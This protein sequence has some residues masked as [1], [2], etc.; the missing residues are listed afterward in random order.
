MGGET[1]IKASP[2]I[3]A[4]TNCNL[5]AKVHAGAF[6]EDLFYR[7]AAFVIA[8]PPLRERRQAVPAL[9]QEFLRRAAV[10]FEKDLQGISPDAMRMLVD[11]DWP[12]NVRELQHAVERAAILSHRAAHRR[13]RPAAGT[14]AAGGRRRCRPYSRSRSA[15]S[16][17][18]RSPN[19]AATAG[20]KPRR[21]I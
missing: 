13:R 6:R 12:G 10:R 15:R 2:R 8:V 16:S 14:A 18:R 5:R 9:A 11:Y 20:A 21:S 19:S 17:K 7:L 1:S 4:A 3:V